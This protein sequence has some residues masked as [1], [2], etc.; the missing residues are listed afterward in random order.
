VAASDFR[1]GECHAQVNVAMTM[2]DE[3][4]AVAKAQGVLS[5]LAPTTPSND[6]IAFALRYT[7][8]LVTAGMTQGFSS[9]A[10]LS[11]L[12]SDAATALNAVA[13]SLDS[14][15]LTRELINNARRA[16]AGLLG[17]FD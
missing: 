6:E 2:D 1:D 13:G 16:V 10:A 5:G 4:K 8:R 7:S 9:E 11:D 15:T 14:G 17:G 3:R 12:R